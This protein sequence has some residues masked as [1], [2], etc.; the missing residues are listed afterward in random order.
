MFSR[1]CSFQNCVLIYAG[2]PLNFNNNSLNGV[3]LE[4]VDAA[5][6][7]VGLLSKFYQSGG[8]S[9][10]FA[11]HLLSTFGKKPEEH[12]PSGLMDEFEDEQ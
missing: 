10:E 12:E 8:Q 5:A 2:G 7:T 6:R 11:E 1:D 4:F 9:R 3:K